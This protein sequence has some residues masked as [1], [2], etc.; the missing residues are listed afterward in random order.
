MKTLEPT[1]A[2]AQRVLAAIKLLHTIIWAIFVAC[3]AA[4]P[5]AACEHHFRLTACLSV[6]IWS[7]CG[8]LAIKRGRCPM[9]IV[10]ER[11][12]AER[13][14]NSDIYLPEWLARWNKL[15]FGSLFVACQILAVIAWMRDR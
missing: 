12:T 4:I 10:A 11:F 13:K 1:S 14:P 6:L 3:I 15:V 9:T 2:E 5:I 7:E 8:V